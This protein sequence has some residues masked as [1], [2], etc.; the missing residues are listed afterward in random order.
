MKQQKQQKGVRGRDMPRPTA[1]GRTTFLP[2]S[3][4][5]WGKGDSQAIGTNHLLGPFSKGAQCG[6]GSFLRSS[7]LGN[8]KTCLETA[9]VALMVQARSTFLCEWI[10]WTEWA[11][12][13]YERVHGLAS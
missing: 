7:E 9:L 4:C 6:E 5:G 11:E 8:N 13:L 3:R 12:S 2:E 1:R 10:L